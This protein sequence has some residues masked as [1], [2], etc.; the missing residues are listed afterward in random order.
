MDSPQPIPNSTSNDDSSNDQNQQADANTMPVTPPIAE[1]PPEVPPT[2]EPP[3]QDV[4][5][6][7]AP[8]DTPQ[9]AGQTPSEDSSV[10]TNPL[11][12]ASEPP[13]PPPP[14]SP[15][16][17]VASKPEPVDRIPLQQPSEHNVGVGTPNIG[18]EEKQIH[19]NVN[20]SS[21]VPLDSIV[22][23]VSQTTPVAPEEKIEVAEYGKN[24]NSQGMKNDPEPQKDPIQ[25][26]NY[27]NPNPQNSP[28]QPQPP[29]KA[30]NPNM[31]L[32]VFILIALV[33]GSSGGFFGFR[34]FD[35]IKTSA[36]TNESPSATISAS[37]GSSAL[38]AY[39]SALYNFSLSYPGDW[40]ASSTDEQ[41][42]SLTF[43]SNQES[44][45]SDPT[46]YKIEINFQNSNGKTLKNWVSAN[47]TAS[48]ETKAA[49]E[50]TVSEKTAYQQEISKSGLK[51]ATYIERG[52]KIMIVTYSAPTEVFGN[53][54]DFY[55]NL[56]DSI[57][58]N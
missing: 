45:E 49:K 27:Q 16:Q 15:T 43:A 58:L 56:V 33:L 25:V 21:S 9:P 57:K 23:P 28:Q 17:P 22:K 37:P 12:G 51:V 8:Q 5:I 48:G 34:Y 35:R 41:A 11:G 13:T 50:I 55:N 26:K 40:F 4:P 10:G 1:N 54:G 42:E 18:V 29:V 52:D 20:Q 6:S 44:L 38:K 2:P 39:T 31:S 3:S 36:S 19:N 32:V 7:S 47:T 30:A 46:G 24:S 14:V 53:G